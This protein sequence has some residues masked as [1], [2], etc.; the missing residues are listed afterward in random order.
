MSSL[1]FAPDGT[2]FATADETPGT[3][4]SLLIRIDPLTGAGTTIGS[5]GYPTEAIA[6]APDGTLFGAADVTGDAK[7]QTLITIDPETGAGII[8]G[9]FGPEFTD[10]DAIAFS[11]DGILF[12]ANLDTGI[13]FKI[14]TAT[15]ASIAV[16][17]IGMC[18]IA[19]L[20]FKP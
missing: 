1:A 13:L 6:F 5:I 14:D 17:R 3:A 11:P 15:G 8:I 18:C 7:A 10:V 12:G 20:S 2:L 9:S 19:G 4:G 16:G